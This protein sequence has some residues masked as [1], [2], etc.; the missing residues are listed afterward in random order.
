MLHLARTSNLIF[1]VLLAPAPLFGGSDACPADSARV[2]TVCVGR[3]EPRVW[4][5]DHKRSSLIKRLMS[6]KAT[7]QD[8]VAGGAV[9]LG[10]E[11]VADP[12]ADYP[13][14]STGNGQ[15]TP[16]PGSDAPSPGVY[17]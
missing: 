17:A 8:L 16:I 9:Q 7:R 10:C 1:V 6:G 11:L 3:Y 12:T 13:A 15:W 14:N 2:G 4:Q 5:I